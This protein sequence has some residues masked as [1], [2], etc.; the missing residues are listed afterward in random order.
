MSRGGSTSF[1]KNW[2]PTHIKALKLPPSPHFIVP[3]SCINITTIRHC[4]LFPP[5]PNPPGKHLCQAIYLPPPPPG[6]TNF[7][8]LH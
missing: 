7:A 1:H 6:Q 2:S 3:A 4:T 5:A 8:R